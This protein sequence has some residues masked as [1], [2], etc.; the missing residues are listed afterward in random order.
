MTKSATAHYDATYFARQAQHGSVA[1]RA[2]L[3]KFIDLI[4]DGSRVLD[5]GC[6]GGFVLAALKEQLPNI[7]CIGVEINDV[8]AATARRNGVD[9]H[10]LLSEIDANSLDVAI[11]NHALE[12][13]EEP[14]S[15]LREIRRVL[16][17]GSIFVCV[18]PCDK[19]SYAYDPHDIDFHLYS[20]SANNL[21]NLMRTAGYEVLTAREI[22]HKWPPGW[23]LVYRYFG[24]AIFHASARVYGAFDRR[25]SQ[26]RVIAR[27]A[28]D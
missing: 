19:P 8:A 22:L 2:E 14:L 17:T 27:A 12:H 7:A 16:K 11:S 23:H 25:R 24:E 18:V 10:K 15:T 3:W 20:W 28:A 26:V 21:G 1:G 6:G 5:F 13:V 9:V 4:P